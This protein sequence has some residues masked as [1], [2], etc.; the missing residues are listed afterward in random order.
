[1]TLNQFIYKATRP[2]GGL[3]LARILA[4]HHPRILM[5]HRLSAKDE[6]GKIH[7]D[8][9]RKQMRLI[10]R[11][12]HPMN[13]TELLEAH[14]QGSVPNHAVVVTFDDGYADFAEY[15]FPIMQEEGIPSTLFITTGFVNGDLWLW[16]DQLRYA[17]DMRVI[18]PHQLR[19]DFKLNLE[20]Q[21][22]PSSLWNALADYS[23]TLSNRDKI[24]FIDYIYSDFGVERP[25]R[26]PDEYLPVTWEQLNK[27]SLSGLDIGSHSV[28]HPILTKL[29]TN[30][31]IFELS[32]SK[33][34]IKKNLGLSVDVFCYPNGTVE[35]FNE[36][37]KECISN[38]GYKYAV[39]AYPD[40]PVL[41]DRWCIKRYPAQ[42][43]MNNFEKN[44]YGMSHI[45]DYSRSNVKMR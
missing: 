15:A 44:V 5:Y 40:G 1:M 7:V 45:Y 18:P 11:H 10:K 39:A 38:A 3:Q 33:R 12:F 43:D 42:Y 28:S 8:Q 13:L 41:D 35:D 20:N 4:R 37:V 31:L 36:E 23:L 14:E 24:A 32:E 22:S 30:E 2:L 6:P 9:F 21:G 25:E 16:P 26:V 19:N 34:M 27:M 17:V 29:E